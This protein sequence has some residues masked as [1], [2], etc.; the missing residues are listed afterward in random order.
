MFVKNVDAVAGNPDEEVDAVGVAGV[1]VGV[2]AGVENEDD[3]GRSPFSCSSSSVAA[4]AE[5]LDEEPLALNPEGLDEE[6]F[7]FFGV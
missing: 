4:L 1:E 5:G 2:V 7:I 6:P 3:F